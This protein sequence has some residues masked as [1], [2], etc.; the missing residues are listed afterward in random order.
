MDSKMDYNMADIKA[1]TDSNLGL[2]SETMDRKIG[3][4]NNEYNNFG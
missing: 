2:I 4:L 1:H 3:S